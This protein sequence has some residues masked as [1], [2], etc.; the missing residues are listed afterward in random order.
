MTSISTSRTANPYE[1][2][3]RGYGYFTLSASQTTNISS[4]D[5]I[6]FN[7]V[8]T[9]NLQMDAST[10]KVTLKA[11]RRYRLSACICA[12]GSGA[13]YS[14]IYLY[15]VTG[16]AVLGK[17]GNCIFTTYS[18]SNLNNSHVVN[19]IF[20]PTVDSQVQVRLG[21][22][23]NLASV[24]M[25]YT[26]WEIEELDS[27]TPSIEK[28]QYAYVSPVLDLTVSLANWTTHHAKGQFYKTNNGVWYLRFQLGGLMTS[29]SRTGITLVF[30]GVVFKTYASSNWQSCNGD[31]NGTVVPNYIQALGGTSNLQYGH[32]SATTVYYTADGFV[33]LDAK[34]TGYAIPSDV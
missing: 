8:Y 18:A 23:A 31:V 4:G 26:F 28:W 29:A 10:Y 22:S 12:T 24:E 17:Y 20:T 16:S 21:A 30:T 33:E 13:G 3:S 1:Y 9:S 34:P 11:N 25:S 2:N 5:P 15:N 32:A 14:Q 27:Y 19:Y 6:K 7:T